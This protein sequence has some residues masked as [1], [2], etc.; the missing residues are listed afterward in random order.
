MV[1]DI[2][3]LGGIKGADKT[4]AKAKVSATGG[5]S[6]SE[7]L[8][9]AQSAETPAEQAPLSGGLGVAGGFVPLED[10]LPKDARGQAR[11]MLKTLQSLAEDA[12][13]GSPTSAVGKLE[14]LAASVD[15]TNL[16][17]EQKRAL[18]EVRTRAAVE[19]AKLKG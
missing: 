5:P 3:G 9:E 18:D 7:F 6:F 15:E 4:K 19:V 8:D 12:L 2:K 16:T 1:F 14:A 10:E 17:E 11:E 13:S